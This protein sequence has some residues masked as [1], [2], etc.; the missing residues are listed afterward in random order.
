MNE[1]ILSVLNELNSSSSDIT[2]SALISM[3][4]LP[5]AS[6]LQHDTDPDRVGGMAAAMLSLGNRATRELSCGKLEQV[7]VKGDDGYILM[8]QAGAEAVLVLTAKEDAKPG[9]LFFNARNAAKQFAEMKELN[10]F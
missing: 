9:L 8:V 1:I 7:L 5:L 10:P 6:V 4:G 2:A 3:D